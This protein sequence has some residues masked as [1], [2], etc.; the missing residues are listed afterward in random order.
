MSDRRLLPA[1]AVLLGGAALLAQPTTAGSALPRLVVEAGEV[2]RANA[3]LSVSLPSH[4]R[5]SDLQL[6]DEATGEVVPLQVGPSR[7]AWAVVPSIPADRA[8][9]Y[10]IEPAMKPTTSERVTATREVSQVRVTVDGRPVFTYVGEPLR[11]PAGVEDVYLRGG[12]IHPVLTPSGR[13]VTADYPLDHKHHHGIWAAWTRTRIDGRSPDFWNMADRTGTVEFERVG[14]AWSGPLTAGFGARHRYMDLR[15]PTPRTVLLEE[16]RVIAYA[17]PPGTRPAHVFDIEITQVLVGTS[18]LELPVY[19]YG[20]IGIRGRDE[21]N[22]RDRASFLTSSGLDRR[23]GHGSRA[24]WAYMGGA[25]DS[26]R[27]GVAVLS[28]PDN[29]RSPQPVRIHPTEPFLNFAPQQAGP[30]AIRPG[31]PF[32]MRYRVIAIDGPPDAAWLESQW[33]AYALPPRISIE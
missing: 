23:T 30:L 26:Q 4:V 7:E 16:W 24:T 31:E 28:H 10:R 33:Q 9:S 17:P 18:P 27:A 22:G 12:Y 1:A 2:A 25:I 15:A 29:A 13:R 14:H 19:R 5:G 11:L 32:T 3:W 8:I 20:G 6:R 21:W